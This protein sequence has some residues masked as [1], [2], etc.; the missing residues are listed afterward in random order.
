M[1]TKLS[2]SGDANSPPGYGSYHGAYGFNAFTHTRTVFSLPGWF[3]SLMSF[4]Y[5]PYDKKNLGWLTVR[6][7]MGFKRGETM[8]DQKIGVKAGRLSI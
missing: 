3:D 6:N 1:E 2:L 8:A 4:R 7:K 5:P